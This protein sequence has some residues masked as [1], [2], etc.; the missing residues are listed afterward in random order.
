MAKTSNPRNVG[1]G[2]FGENKTPVGL[3][4]LDAKTKDS[5]GKETK[6]TY[7]FPKFADD[8]PLNVMVDA[9]TY[10]NSKK[11]KV[12][13]E[14][15]IRDYVNTAIKNAARSSKLAE[16]NGILKL[17][18]DPEAAIRNMVD[19]MVLAYGVPREMAEANV[20]ALIAQGSQNQPAAT[21][22]ETTK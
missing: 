7:Q 14:S 5:D 15:V 16:I 12:S 21:S 19:Q 18:E 1:S 9:L 11:E 22:P 2:P 6:F 10:T 3:F 17:R 13:G 8:V 20:R 4:E